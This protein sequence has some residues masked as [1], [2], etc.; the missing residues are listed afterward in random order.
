MTAV[1]VL[2]GWLAIC[3][4]FV[5]LLGFWYALEEMLWRLDQR[6]AERRLAE[7]LSP[8]RRPAPASTGR[9]DDREVHPSDQT[10]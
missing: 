2:L 7:L 5:A 10:I 3:L 6:A 8:Q 4:A 9:A 1:H